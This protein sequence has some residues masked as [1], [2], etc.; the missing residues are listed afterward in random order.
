MPQIWGDNAE[1]EVTAVLFRTK[2]SYQLGTQDFGFWGGLVA[3][4]AFC[5]APVAQ[6]SRRRGCGHPHMSPASGAAL[7]AGAGF[8]GRSEGHGMEREWMDDG[9]MDGE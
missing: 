1:A 4:R 7:L 9:M 2:T 5:L 8:S 3:R 6:W